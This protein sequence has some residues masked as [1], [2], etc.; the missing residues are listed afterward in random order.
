M[1]ENDLLYGNYRNRKF[2]DIYP[3]VDDF[4]QDYDEFNN[5]LLDASVSRTAVDTIW[6]LLSARYGNSTVA[7]QNEAQFKL[8]LFTLVF[9]YGPTWEKRL[10]IQKAVRGMD[11]EEIRK[12]GKAIYNTALNPSQ[13][14]AGGAGAP[15]GEGTN[16]LDELTYINQQ[17]TTNYK[18]SL[19]EA[20]GILTS[21]LETDVTAEFLDKFKRLF[22]TVVSPEV[23]LWY[24]SNMDGTIAI[25]GEDTPPDYTPDEPSYDDE[26]VQD[27]LKQIDE[28]NYEIRELEASV[29]DL[30]GEKIQLNNQI[31]SLNR[32]VADYKS[33]V[34]TLEGNIATLNSQISNLQ[35]EVERLQKY[36]E[37]L[38][39]DGE[40]QTEYINELLQQISQ[41]EADKTDLQGQINT[42]DNTISYLNGQISDLSSQLGEKDKTIG[43]LNNTINS[44]QQTIDSLN[45]QITQLNKDLQAKDATIKDKDGQIS[46]LNTTI[47]QKD[48]EI[49]GLNS[50]IQSKNSTIASLNQD[51]KTKDSQISNLTSQNT[52]LTNANANYAAFVVE[53][54]AW[55]EEGDALIEE[56]KNTSFAELANWIA[57]LMAWMDRKP[58]YGG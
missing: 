28:L 44:K 36:I 2:N 17:N 7:S 56:G 54:T 30:E 1:W 33:R 5:G 12:G 25:P 23:P 37:T 35:A 10:E 51:I 27:L 8:K 31:N 45:S 6:L 3:E 26:Y 9:Q 22:L 42:K 57:K 19:P 4:E 14:V 38:E 43:D 15:V 50:D 21:L 52:T 53:Y 47:Q 48:N 13:P 58:I 46:Q 32:D 41:L 39:G 29:A 34:S 55:A 20:Y 11:I 16:T 49:S 40:G 18:K 24:I